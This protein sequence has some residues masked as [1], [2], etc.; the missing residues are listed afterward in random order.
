MPFALGSAP[1]GRRPFGLIVDLPLTATIAA[2]VGAVIIY[3][4]EITPLTGSVVRVAT[5]Q[6]ATLVTDSLPSTPFNATLDGVPTWKSSIVGGDTFGGIASGFGEAAINNASGEYDSL[7]TAPIDGAHVVVNMG[8]RGISYDQF[9][10]I[11]DGLVETA[12]VNEDQI[13]IHFKDDNKRLEVPAQPNLYGGTGGIDGDANVKGK[14]KPICLGLPPNISVPLIDATNL[15]YQIHDGQIASVSAVYD[16]SVALTANSTPDYSSY[17]NLIAATITPG[18]YATCLALGIFRLG[19]KP[20]GTVTATAQG[21]VNNGLVAGSASGATLSDTASLIHYLLTVSAANIVV[22]TGSVIAM[23]AAQGAAIGY[24]IG[25]DDNKT[26]RQVIDELTKPIVG[27]GGFRQDRSFALGIMVLAGTTSVADYTDKDWFDLKRV[28]L[29][30]GVSPP[31]KRVR[32]AYSLN[33]TIQADVDATVDAGTQTLRKDPYS[34]A[35][36][37]DTTTSNIV[38]AAFGSTAQDPDVIQSWFVNSA[39]AVTEANRQLVLWGGAM[40]SLFTVDLT[41]AAMARKLGDIV[42]LTD[43]ATTPRFGLGTIKYGAVVE[44]DNGFDELVVTTQV[45]V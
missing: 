40:R 39:D 21:A 6:Y 24:W 3:T 17:A 16:R 1:F 35:S 41:E 9:V 26:L 44:F 30:S 37:T 2:G 12:E 7:I 19:A 28:P 38:I 11:F 31:P 13:L 5:E 20:D 15:V 34:I 32:M 42:S 36:S 33:W 29:P 10:K 22:D 4:M 18:R 14:R 23:K 43:T 45:F 27:W 25:P 8:W